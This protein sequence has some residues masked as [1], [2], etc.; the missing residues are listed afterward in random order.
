LI[1]LCLLAFVSG[2]A[3][4]ILFQP[5]QFMDP[6]EIIQ[7]HGYPAEEHQTTTQDGYILTMHRIPH[8]IAGTQC[9]FTTPRRVVLLQHGLLSSSFDYVSLLPEKSLS[10]YLAD[11]GYDVWIGNNRGNIY[12][13]SHVNYS[14]LD[15]RFWNFS[16]DEMVTFDTHS[17]VDYI[18]AATNQ[19][20][21]YV[22]AHSQVILLNS[23]NYVNSLTLFLQ[24]KH[25]FALAPA[26]SSRNM[27]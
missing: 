8:G 12:S 22:V 13:N 16:F 2:T 27:Q 20:Y 18:L 10:Y 4:Q 25:F 19:N 9:N 6:V 17:I 26:L 11:S 23:L 14:S 7:Y 24:I 5:E 15:S 1:Q 21:L 3:A